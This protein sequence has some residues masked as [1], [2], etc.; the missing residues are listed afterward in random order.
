MLKY[1]SNPAWKKCIFFKTFQKQLKFFLNYPFLMVK[2][3]L[4][5]VSANLGYLFFNVSHPL[6]MGWFYFYI[7]LLSGTVSQTFWLRYVLFLFEN[8]N[9][10]HKCIEWKKSLMNINFFK[11]NTSMSFSLIQITWRCMTDCPYFT[12]YLSRNEH[13]SSVVKSPTRKLSFIYRSRGFFMTQ[14]LHTSYK[15]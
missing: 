10:I 9:I 12:L 4:F 14:R 5:A 2:I 11:I 6:A 7:A 1:Y 8:L 13:I 3:I 15:A